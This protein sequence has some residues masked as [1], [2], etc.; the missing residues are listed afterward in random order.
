MGDRKDKS[1]GRLT[2]K[3]ASLVGTREKGRRTKEAVL[4]GLCSEG[5][6]VGRDCS[7]EYYESICSKD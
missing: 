7:G 6:V 1:Q 2:M 5:M 4:L 3:E